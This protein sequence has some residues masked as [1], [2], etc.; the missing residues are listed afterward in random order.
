M[1]RFLTAW[2]IIGWHIHHRC[3]PRADIDFEIQRSIRALEKLLHWASRSIQNSSKST[4]SKRCSNRK[5]K[6]EKKFSNKI[7]KF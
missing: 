4:S 2:F 3:G 6:S 1:F 7:Q 5:Q